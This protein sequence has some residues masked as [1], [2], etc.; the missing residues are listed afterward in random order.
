M[1]FGEPVLQLIKGARLEMG[2]LGV[3]AKVAVGFLELRE[4]RI[5]EIHG[6]LQAP[7]DDR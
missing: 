7:I 1:N 6:V 4:C 3:T 5:D 2:L